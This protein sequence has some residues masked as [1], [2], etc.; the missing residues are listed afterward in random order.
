MNISLNGQM[1]PTTA[2]TLDTLLTEAGF[3][4]QQAFACALNAA[5]VPRSQWAQQALHDG[6]RIDV[7]APITGG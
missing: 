1:R 3:D 2:Q 7:V 6:D 5:F 4:R